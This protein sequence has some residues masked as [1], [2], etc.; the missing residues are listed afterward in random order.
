MIHWLTQS[1][2]SPS[3]IPLVYRHD[4]KDLLSVHV[5]VIF[6]S[7]LPAERQDTLTAKEHIRCKIFTNLLKAGLDINRYQFKCHV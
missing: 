7:V 2:S 3:P 4:E 6:L 5:Y 1:L